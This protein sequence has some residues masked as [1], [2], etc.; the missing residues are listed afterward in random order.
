MAIDVDKDG[1]V[2]CA[3]YV[4]MD[5]ALVL[6]EDISMGGIEAVETFL[7]HV[8]PTSVIIPNRSPSDLIE[9]LERDAHRPDD[10]IDSESGHG[11]Y[12]LRHVVSM[13][14]DY[15]SG[16]EALANI[17]PGQTEPSGVEVAT[18]G[19]EPVL[20]IGSL[21]HGRLMRLAEKVNLESCLSVGCAS[22]ILTDLER[23][24]VVEDTT[25]SF[26]EPTFQF[27]VRSIEMNTP[28][29][30]MLLSGDTLISLQILQSELHPNLQTRSSNGS[31]PKA[32]EALSI[33]GLL[34]ALASSA[35]GKRRLRQI[36]LR[37]STNIRLIQ[38]RHRCIEVLLRPD[39]AE[40]TKHMRK[41]L[42]KL[43][44]TKTLLLHVRKGVDRVRG[45]LSIRVGDWK[46]LLRFAMV[47]AQ[48]KRA[49]HTL[50]KSVGV[51]IFDRIRTEIDVNRFLHIG[52]IIIR[53]IDFQLSK[54]SGHTEIQTEASEYL[55]GLRREFADVCHMLPEIK[56][57]VVRESPREAAQYIRHCTVMPQE[58]FLIA[59]GLDPETGEG[60]YH[61]Q[62]SLEGEWMRYF[63]NEDAVYYK[64]Q[65]ML[66][67]DSQ[68]GDLPSRISEEE[69]EVIMALAA[70]VLEHEEPILGAAELFGELDSMLAFALAAEKY[71]WAAPTLTSSNTIDI[72][73]GR[74]PLQ[75]L[76]VPS[77]IPND[78]SIAGGCGG[79]ES[80]QGAAVGQSEEKPST[81]ILTGPN[82]SGKSVYMKQV[83]LIVYLAHTG[84]YVPATHATVGV[85][86]RI[87]TRIATR[88]T[89][90]NDESAFLVDLKQAAFSMN[91]ATRRSLLLID[92]FGKG[93]NS[94]SGSALLA[95]YLTYFLDL[96][97]EAPKVLAGTHFHEVFDNG[98]LQS[99]QTLAFAH[100]DVRLD[101]EAEDPED[102]VTFLFRLLPGRGTSSL[103]V[104]CA[105]ANG[106]PTEVISRAEEIVALLDKNESLVDAYS[107][108]SEK[109]EQELA[110]AKLV[111]RRFLTLEVPALGRGQ[112]KN[113]FKIREMLEAVLAIEHVGGTLR[114]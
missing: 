2:G 36:L 67:L 81:L 10:G 71:N 34:L 32:K 13:Q 28:I 85:T 22:A 106:V 64:N 96:E 61:G 76:L 42:R 51:E 109:D 3:Y 95:A 43:K 30:T 52:D 9:F 90:V 88:E 63:T 105:A 70:A 38:E 24:R 55:D 8:Q 6:E 79:G 59:V 14:F 5:E 44:N 102:Q 68:Y 83:A 82:N 66:D 108:L 93:T 4:A 23:R 50:E 40:V 19:E 25:S 78:C 46:A 16:K 87:L 58:G 111:A 17:D 74:H 35:Q 41:L 56:E 20:S 1:K 62:G 53:T 110:Q 84:S 60:I 86:D 100:M 92:E 45:Q 12:I 31:E 65:L 114:A 99:R 48:L 54:E 113:E 73:G 72:K 21:A 39:N 112:K 101:P 7:L 27:R 104:L 11:A 80:G 89:V 107:K 57:S 29:D 26:D 15:D 98:L 33:T 94:E 47:S 18:A 91:F 97:V 77:F 103:G 75:E 37:P 49:I 69:I